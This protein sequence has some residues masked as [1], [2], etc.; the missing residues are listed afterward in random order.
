MTGRQATCLASNSEQ[1]GQA[2]VR[3]LLERMK[4]QRTEAV[5]L[6]VASR[7]VLGTTTSPPP[8]GV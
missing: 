6:A 2:A 8:G 5:K 4:G 7:L 3:L 1:M